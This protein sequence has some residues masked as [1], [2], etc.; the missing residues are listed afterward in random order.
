ML[1]ENHANFYR[2]EN[3]NN[4][5]INPTAGSLFERL[6]VGNFD[7]LEY[8]EFSDYE[9]KRGKIYPADSQICTGKNFP[10]RFGP[11]RVAVPDIHVAQ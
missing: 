11:I 9:P 10:S 4:S 7:L 1:S 3:I 5:A 8:D 6:H 2:L